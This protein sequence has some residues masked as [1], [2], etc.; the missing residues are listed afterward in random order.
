MAFAL[1]ATSTVTQ[2]LFC[3]SKA[4]EAKLRHSSG[5]VTINTGVLHGMGPAIKQNLPITPPSSSN[6]SRTLNKD[7]AESWSERSGDGSAIQTLQLR[8]QLSS[9]HP[10]RRTP[11]SRPRGTVDESSSP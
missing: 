5:E 2:V 8:E 4:N 6:S 1:E 10:D 7:L 9:C 11:C 3:K